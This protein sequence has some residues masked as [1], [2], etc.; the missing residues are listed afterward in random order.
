MN[1]SLLSAIKALDFTAIRNICLALSQEERQELKSY[2]AEKNFNFIFREV[3][4]EEKRYHFSNKELAIISYTIM[5]VCNTL[6]EVRKIELFQNIEP[7][8]KGNY[9]Y[10]LSSLED[11]VLLDFVQTPQGAYMIEGIQLMYKDNP[12][13]M[14]FQILW[15]VYKAGY[16]PLNEGVFIQRM[17]DLNWFKAD[18]HLTKYLL[19]HPETVVLFP[20]VPTYIQDTIFTTEEWKKIYHTLDKKG[21]LTNK[22][23]ILHAFIEAL[24]NPWK[25]TV[26]DMYCRWIETLEPSHQELLYNQ[27]TLFALLSSDKTSVVN[28]VMKLIKEISSEKDFDF[29]A[30][31]DNFA[32]CF[33]TQ[34]IA[35]SQLIGLSILENSYKKQAPSNPDYRE[36]LAI[37]FTVPDAKLQEKVATLL[38]SYF[39]GK[40]LAEVVAPYQDYLKGKAQELLPFESHNSS[41]SSDPSYSN[42]P[43][44]LTKEIARAA[45]TPKTWDDLLFLI[46]DCIRERS[47]LALDLFFE[48]L[49][50]LQ[51]QIPADYPEQVKPYLNQLLSNERA[52]TSLF[53]QFLDSWCSQSPIPLVYNTN[54][55]WE[56][57][58]ELYKEKKYSQAEKFN[59]LREIH[60]SANKAKKIFP[61]FFN[62]IACTLLKLK[63]KDTLP[64]ISTPTHAPFYIEP[65]TFLE[66]IIQYEKAD[67]TPMQEDVIIGL[68][69]LLPTEITEAQKQ[70]ALS[71]TGDYAPALQYYF[72]VSNTITITNATRVLWGQVLRLKDIDGVFPELE[73]PQKPNLQGLVRPFYLKYEVELTKI[74]GVERNKIILEDNWDKK[75][76]TYSY[77]NELGA[78]Y[79]NVSPMG[80]VIDED[81]DYELSL[82]P[83]YIDGWL[84]KYLLPYTQGMDSES[85]SEATR[86]MSLLLEHHL[87][88]YHGGWLMVATCLLAE[89]KNLRDLAAEYILLSLQKGETLTYLAEAIG[90]LLAHKYAPIARF[91]EFLDL[92]TRDPKIKAFQKA[93]VEAYLPLA[94][95][96]EKKPTNHKKLVAFSC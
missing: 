46:G 25:K 47:P 60:V 8:V 58:Q 10:F 5:C 53:Y 76:S 21:Y 50:Q 14:S 45:R 80:K 70:L 4:K 85:L 66:R 28:F 37:L 65:L 13:K 83:R 3:L 54:K 31:A 23:A 93:V 82:N 33:A 32:L 44:S 7:Y 69:R 36:Q 74:N 22:N 77:Y 27:H 56:E 89:R 94:E 35:K 87:P 92:P 84:C 49:N 55:E 39:S 68:N 38:T 17:Y 24:L 12:S 64:F 95:K 90:T 2:F 86:V 63:E 59:K 26:L 81:I 40:G 51:A 71:L 42:E 67:K 16:I 88:I 29:Q 41:E 91:V 75:H 78:N 61:F 62:K 72:E 34:K 20:S 43:N 1:D 48:G 18:E 73:I 96:Q 11:E 79:Y 52:V 9:Y 6:E 15:S 57:L 19:K 30:F